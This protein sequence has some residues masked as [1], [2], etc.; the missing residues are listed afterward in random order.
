M[1]QR[2]QKERVVVSHRVRNTIPVQQQQQRLVVEPSVSCTCASYYCSLLLYTVYVSN[3][4]VQ[5][6]GP[7]LPPRRQPAGRPRPHGLPIQDDLGARVLDRPAGASAPRQGGYRLSAGRSTSG[8]NR[9]PVCYHLQTRPADSRRTAAQGKPT[10]PS[11]PAPAGA[12]A[13]PIG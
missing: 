5:D 12:A 1:K 13:Q 7:H 3:L 8:R 10:L 4:P 11:I 2:K 6:H 9:S